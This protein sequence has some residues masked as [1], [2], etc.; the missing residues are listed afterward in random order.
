MKQFT[1]EPE[2]ITEFKKFMDKWNDYG[3][4]RLD[5]AT[6]D[7]IDPDG[8]SIDE[9]IYLAAK[10]L[11]AIICYEGETGGYKWKVVNKAVRVLGNGWAQLIRLPKERSGEYEK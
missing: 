7:A 6:V 1:N 11:V 8:L 5:R 9:K 2:F 10:Y 4:K 3:G